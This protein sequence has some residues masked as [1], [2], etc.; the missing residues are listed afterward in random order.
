MPPLGMGFPPAK[1][2]VGRLRDR[3]VGG[4]TMR[5]WDKKGLPRLNTLR[6]DL[7]LEPVAHFWDQ[8]HQAR[9]EL[10]M[11]S[12]D[13]DFPARLP[14]PARYVGPVLDDPTWVEPWTPP[15]GDDPLVLVA[16]SSTFQD[17]GAT[18]QRVI[19]GVATLPVRAVVTTGP[20]LDP[21]T[22]RSPANISVVASAPHSEVLKHATLVITHGGHGTVVRTLAAGVPMVVMP[23]GRDQAENAARVTARGAGI[24][25]PRKARPDK[26]AAAVRKII[27]DPS[28]RANAGRLGESVR[29]DA[30]RSSLVEELEAAS[31]GSYV[32]SKPA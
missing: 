6:A 2:A 7:G 14:A 26:L 17:Q 11:T 16:L 18:L 21:V 31:D 13:F 29:R 25:R 10:V 5:V 9:R 22:P 15:P 12:P 8:V 20:A 24:K 27:D 3:L 32:S 4:F 23:H 19:D 1:G 28:Y 30:A